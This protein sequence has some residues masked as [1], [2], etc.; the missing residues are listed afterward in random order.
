MG[1]DLLRHCFPK[2]VDL[3]SFSQ[4]KLNSVA[5]RLKARPCKA[6]SFQIPI[7]LYQ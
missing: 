5:R 2:G 4:A 3:P 7:E 1:T 6:L